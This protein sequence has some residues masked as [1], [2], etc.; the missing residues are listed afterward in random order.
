MPPNASKDTLRTDSALLHQADRYGTRV[1]NWATAAAHMAGDPSNL[2]KDDAFVPSLRNCVERATY[3]FNVVVKANAIDTNN[4]LILVGRCWLSV[5]EESTSTQPQSQLN[6][7]KLILLLLHSLLLE[8]VDVTNHAC[9]LKGITLSN[10]LTSLSC[11]MLLLQ[12]NTRH[13][14]RGTRKP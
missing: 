9:L 4:V 13:Q 14:M 10:R 2:T 7:P 8:R 5:L 12:E 1:L 6:P 11:I 3:G